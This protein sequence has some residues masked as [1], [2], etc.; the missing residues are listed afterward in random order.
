MSAG[1]RGVR[2]RMSRAAALLV[3][4][5]AACGGDRSGSGAEWLTAPARTVTLE[6]SL[7][8]DR[9][10]GRT[11]DA[12]GGT[13]SATGSDGT[14]FRLRIPEGALAGPERITLIPIGEIRGLPLEGGSVG[15]VHIEPSGLQLLQAATLTIR[16]ARDVP[17]REQVAFGYFGTGQDAH[18]YPLSGDT[19]R[20]EMQIVHFSGYGLGRAAPDAP[21]RQALQR[22]AAAEARLMSRIAEVLDERESR[23]T[24]ASDGESGDGVLNALIEYY[25]A[26][27]RPLMQRAETDDRLAACCMARYWGWERRIQLYGADPETAGGDDHLR[28]GTAAHELERRRAEAALSAERIAT[29]AYEKGIQ[30]AV[31]RCR[32]DHDLDAVNTLLAL[33]RSRQ[34]LG[35]AMD[36]PESAA[37]DR[38]FAEMR[39]CFQF[40][41]EFGS[42]FEASADG[43]LLLDQVEARARVDGGG[44]AEEARSSAPL[45]YVRHHTTF[46]GG[47]ILGRDY[48]ADGVGTRPGTFIVERI[49]R[50]G[51][52]RVD[53]EARCD[54]E[55]EE[56]QPARRDTM[57]ITFRVVAPTDIARVSAQGLS[58]GLVEAHRWAKSWDSSHA[59]E[60]LGGALED[61]DAEVPSAVYRLVLIGDEPGIWEA[62]FQEASGQPPGPSTSEDGYLVV[63]H[64]PR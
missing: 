24:V 20:I 31:R 26:A 1:S 6:T 30:R 17:A 46:T 23:G 49:E 7:E 59:A 11:I 4:I 18:R 13:V 21:G 10:A 36:G 14:R 62:E 60:R 28:G 63:R 61:D 47:V 35:G 41:V 56:E 15:A 45:E 3:P 55:P 5:L 32:E 29:N 19:S 54:G 33:E 50:G 52:L 25:D 22:S 34:L 38:A 43:T 37:F 58:S 40:E 48:R 8:M 42:T 16:P 9:A 39:D 44:T 2:R 51:N 12:R 27:L 57:T 64:T 53:M